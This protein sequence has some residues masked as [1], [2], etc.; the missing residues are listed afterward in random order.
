MWC[1]LKSLFVNRRRNSQRAVT[2][3]PVTAQSFSSPPP[4][5]PPCL[6]RAP[7]YAKGS[8]RHAQFLYQTNASAAAHRNDV[9]RSPSL[10]WS[11]RSSRSSLDSYRHQWMDHEQDDEDDDD[12]EEYDK[13]HLCLKSPFPSRQQHQHVDDDERRNW[14][15]AFR[16]SSPSSSL[17]VLIWRD[18]CNDLPFDYLTSK[19]NHTT[20]LSSQSRH[21]RRTSAC[22]WFKSHCQRLDLSNNCLEMCIQLFDMYIRLLVSS[23]STLEHDTKIPFHEFDKRL[24]VSILSVSVQHE[25]KRHEDSIHD[26]Q[27]RIQSL[28]TTTCLDDSMVITTTNRVGRRGRGDMKPPTPRKRTLSTIHP[29]RRDDA[30]H[31]DFKKQVGSIKCPLTPIEWIER[32]VVAFSTRHWPDWSSSS[33]LSSCTL[34]MQ[35]SERDMQSCHSKIMHLY[36]AFEHASRNPLLM[37]I[38]V[39]QSELDQGE[40][41]SIERRHWMYFIDAIDCDFIQPHMSPDEKMQWYACIT[42]PILYMAPP[43]AL[44]SSSSSKTTS[45][46]PTRPTLGIEV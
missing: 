21:G 19:K 34:P 26:L 43:A 39:F 9:S 44:S 7:M 18:C 8:H 31:D 22:G 11:A 10:T 4:P 37:A 45:V 16:S 15:V 14:Q 27:T 32:F 29:R 23:S 1:R 28:V 2:R 41:A 13:N 6:R 17:Y 3:T 12:D 46:F 42:D 33:S 24:C 5:P 40:F 20:T 38:A 35:A 25:S 30:G 36:T